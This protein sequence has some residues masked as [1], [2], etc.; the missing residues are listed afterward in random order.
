VREAVDNDIMFQ[1]PDSITT[2]EERAEDAQ[3]LSGSGL[4]I[5]DRFPDDETA[6]PATTGLMSRP[7]DADRMKDINE[8]TAF[9]NYK[10][11]LTNSTNTDND[12]KN[13]QGML[14]ELGYKAGKADNVS[15]PGTERALRKFQAINGLTINGKLDDETMAKLKSS[16]VPM[17][18]PDPPKKDA[19]V[20]VLLDTDLEIFNTEVGKIESGNAYT[21]YKYDTPDGKYKKGDLM[22]GGA[23][24]AYL[25]RYQMGTA[26]LKDSGYNTAKK[27]NNMTTAQKEAFIKDPDLQDA[28]FKKY[29]KKNHIHL[30]KNSQAYRDMTKEEKLGILGYAH[31]QGATAAE[32]YLVTGVSGSDAFGTKG[33]KYTDALRVAFAEQV[34][35]QSKAQ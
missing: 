30:T 17:A 27:H 21:Y 31:N 15:G 20:T 7:Y 1:S 12:V 33:T 10:Y 35:T 19:R 24:G 3:Y 11:N 32:E 4:S 26:A 25:G 29:T 34:R 13:V 23:G 14:T 16:D 2:D 8:S 18:F 22:Y 28:E 9:K 6:T 5:E